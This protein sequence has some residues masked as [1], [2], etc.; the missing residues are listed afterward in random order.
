[1]KRTLLL[2]LAVGIGIS[3]YAQNTTTGKSLVKLPAS[4][5]NKKAFRPLNKVD[6]Q[7]QVPFS[8][9]NHANRKSSSSSSKTGAPS[10]APLAGTGT[11]IGTTYYDL[12]SNSAIG[13]RIYRHSNGNIAA[14]WTYSGQA[15][16][17]SDRGTGYNFFDGTS[18]GA[19]PTTRLENARTGWPSIGITAS[20]IEIGVSHNTDQSQLHIF[21]RATAGTGAWTQDITSLTSP[22]TGGNWWPRLVIGGPNGESVHVISITY[23][24]ASGGS[25]YMGLDGAFTYSRSQDGGA[26]WDI[27]HSILPGLDTTNYL[28]FGGDG[29]AIDARDNYVAIVAGDENNDLVLLKSSDNGSSWTRTLL[30]SFPI[31][32][33]DP[34]ASISDWD[35]DNVADTIWSHDGNYA[36]GIDANGV[37]HVFWGAYRLLQ[38]APQAGWSFFPGTDGLYYWNET[39]PAA[40]G[41]NNTTGGTQAVLVAGA[42]DLNSNQTLDVSDFGTYYNS[43]TSIPNVGFSGNT[44]VLSY[45]SIVEGTD[46]G[47]GKSY[48]HVYLT[49]SNDNGVTWTTPYDIIPDVEPN[50]ADFTEGAY[51]DLA[52]RMD[53][54]VHLIF[55]KDYNPG[56]G[57]YSGTASPPDPNNQGQL[58]DIVYYTIPVTEL[59]SVSET[60]AQLSNY[61][62]FPNPA[63]DVVNISFNVNQPE[64]ATVTIYN[65]IGQEV[66]SFDNEISAGAHTLTVY[67]AKYNAG[68]YFITTSV[69][70]N[71]YTKKLVIK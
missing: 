4:V 44:I 68:V 3:A 63:E 46:D 53:N 34:A 49:T 43:L 54:N 47:S 25:M 19:Q 39:M 60:S 65:M 5:A 31:Q 71:T 21:K 37:A 11:V 13:D 18:W 12:Q 15:T 36:V 32:K 8:N 62:V 10:V 17:W 70:G 51:A 69:A 58:N 48:R 20:G 57:V 29:Y 7:E 1:M 28:G 22:I 40:S 33:W 26:T 56:Y 9:L 30:D 61:S 6:K 67:T 64:K 27:V 55:Q 52:P 42:L 2:G 50:N 41:Y 16:G 66:A 23:P 45:S 38:D 35:G 24:V 14:T 59:T